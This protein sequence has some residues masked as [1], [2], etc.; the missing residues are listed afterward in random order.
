MSSVSKHVAERLQL[1]AQLQQAQKLDGIWPPGRR[2]GARFQQPDHDNLPDMRRWRWMNFQPM[3]RCARRCTEIVKAAMHGG[4]L[5]RQLLAFSRR[6]ISQPRDIAMNVW[7]AISR[8]CS[9][10]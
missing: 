7:S 6:Q 5:T 9:G 10:A 8:K 1:E 3:T 4:S 2:C